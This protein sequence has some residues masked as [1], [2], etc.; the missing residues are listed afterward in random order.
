MKNSLP[1][2]QWF[3]LT[4]VDPAATEDEIQEML[5]DCSI[6]VPIENIA[7]GSTILNGTTVA[8][9]SLPDNEL[10]TLMQRA[11]SQTPF[12][13]KLLKVLRPRRSR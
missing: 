12:K 4:G 7:L 1:R 8:I 13:G 9:V 6:D 3:T 11:I 10:C 2:G 5:A